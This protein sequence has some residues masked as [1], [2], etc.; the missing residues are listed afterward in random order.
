[1]GCGRHCAL[2]EKGVEFRHT[3]K[4]LNRIPQERGVRGEKRERGKKKRVSITL[5]RATEYK[6]SV[7]RK[8]EK[9]EGGEK[10][11]KR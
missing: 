8:R 5:T 3:K 9:G 2:N 6:Y 10:K 11:R 4:R 1:M 7:R